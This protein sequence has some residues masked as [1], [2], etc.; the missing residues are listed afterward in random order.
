MAL[1]ET[2]SPRVLLSLPDDSLHSIFANLPLTTVAAL[3]GACKHTHTL[4]CAEALWQRL[5]RARWPTASAE[6][7]H[8]RALH[9]ERA[10]LPR[11][12]YLWSCMDAIEQLLADRPPEWQAGVAQ[13]A[14]RIGAGP[15]PHGAAAYDAW[16]DRV[17]GALPLPALR[18][19]QR[20]LRELSRGLDLFYDVQEQAHA[21]VRGNCPVPTHSAHAQCARTVRT[22]S[23]HARCMHGVHARLPHLAGRGARRAA[24]GALRGAAR[25]AA[26]AVGAVAAAGG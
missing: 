19:L 8:W 10:A 20:W 13:H 18:E 7:G 12:Q 1:E 15:V 5:L 22:H 25:C 26:W 14:I 16:A 23:A 9:R 6:G 21:E 3:A 24:L 4:S 2:D 11:W 17:R